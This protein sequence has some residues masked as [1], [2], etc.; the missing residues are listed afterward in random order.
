[1]PTNNDKRILAELRQLIED[2][3]PVKRPIAVEIQVIAETPADTC[4]ERLREAYATM[5]ECYKET[6][7]A[8]QVIRQ[9]Y[10]DE[11]RLNELVD[12]LYA[13]RETA[14]F[15][16]D[17]RKE[18][19]RT[20]DEV[21]KVLGERHAMSVEYD[22]KIPGRFANAYPKVHRQLRTLPT[23]KHYP[24]L[25]TKLMLWFGAAPDLIDQGPLLYDEGEFKSEVLK[26]SYE[27]FQDYITRCTLANIPLPQWLTD[28]INFVDV[29][30]ANVRKQDDLL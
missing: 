4:V 11:Q 12:I 3:K 23:F 26:L 19:M 30:A 20:F 8:L 14:G 27:G 1:M 9:K 10:A 18:F 2:T 21:E 25:Y 6:F 28:E 16:D 29:Y 7:E 13:L 15:A 24:E 17:I 22:K 5:K